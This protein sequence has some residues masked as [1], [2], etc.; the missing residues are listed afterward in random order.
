MG[1]TAEVALHPA[2]GQGNLSSRRLY[3][4]GIMAVAGKTAAVSA[5]ALQLACL[6]G[7]HN[8]IIKFL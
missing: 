3:G 6:D 5:G 4:T 2:Y 8:V 1:G 7:V